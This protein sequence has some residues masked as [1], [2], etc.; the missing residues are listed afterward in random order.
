MN[1]K[2][3]PGIL[4]V[5]AALLIFP[6]TGAIPPAAAQAGPSVADLEL[7]AAVPAPLCPGGVIRYTL[8]LHNTAAAGGLLLA[9]IVDPIPANTAY[10]AGSATN[11]AAF[12]AAQNRVRWEGRLGPG[13]SASFAFEARVNN[14]VANGATIINNATGTLSDPAGAPSSDTAQHIAAVNCPTPTP[15]RTPTATNTPPVIVNPPTPTPTNTPPVIVIPP[16]ATPTPRPIASKLDVA[17]TSIEITQGTQSLQVLMP[18]VEKRNTIVRVYV[19]SVSGQTFV[20]VKARLKLYERMPNN[21]LIEKA[22]L[23]PKNKPQ[24]RPDGGDRLEMNHS[25]WFEMPVELT[26]GNVRFWAE[27]NYDNALADTDSGHNHLWIERAFSAVESIK[28][29]LVPVRAWPGGDPNKSWV[30]QYCKGGPYCM[31]ILAGLFRWHPVGEVNWTENS[32]ALTP[33]DPKD[34]WDPNNNDDRNEINIALASL[35]ALYEEYY[36]KMPKLSWYGMLASQFGTYGWANIGVAHGTWNNVLDAN[37][38]WLNVGS[39]ILAHE[40]GHNKGLNHVS[41]AGDANGNGVL[42]EDEAGSIDW[43]YPW[44]YQQ[45]DKGNVI[46]ECQI[47]D[48]DPKGYYGLDVYYK[49]GLLPAPVVISNDPAATTPNLG[50]PMMGY[51]WPNYISPWEYCK[52]LAA[53]GVSCT[54]ANVDGKAVAAVMPA[55]AAVQPAPAPV[56]QTATTPDQQTREHIL[57]AVSVNAARDTVKFYPALQLRDL[58]PESA[59]AIAANAAK[60]AHDGPEHGWFV[61]LEDAAGNPLAS[62]PISFETVPSH[63][64]DPS[65]LRFGGSFVDIVPFPTGVKYLRVRHDGALVASQTVSANPPSVQLLAPQ[66]GALTVGTTVQWQGSDFDGGPLHYTLLYSPDNGQSWQPLVINTTVTNISLTEDLLHDMPGSNQGKLKVLVTDGINTAEAVSTGLFNVAGSS[67]EIGVLAPVNGMKSPLGT[68][69]NFIANISD[70]EDGFLDGAAVRWV[71]D[72]DGELGTGAAFSTD[73]LSFGKH[74]ITLTATDRDSMTAQAT[75]Q[76]MVVGEQ[77]YL[78]VLLR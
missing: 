66:S 69:V 7:T 75:V 70:V 6:V 49:E 8:T 74:V 20:G 32:N 31:Q 51:K 72:R 37:S 28:L 67:P 1:S 3:I 15:T 57:L 61:T 44:S 68:V 16:T 26:K 38:P 71:S 22:T 2:I 29:R 59:A 50:Y 39:F 45:D 23:A 30:E 9:E 41:C 73:Q 4:L 11:G 54:W 78:P 58:P 34:A 48:I 46:S 52:M 19:K 10:V 12:D 56:I 5:L 55:P 40:L 27:L 13:Q 53:Y 18:L 76:I 33:A 42:D 14:G 64:E 62:H 77:V 60:P 21:Q 17:V 36:P 65:T 43:T 35:K 24:I 63:L 47:A 25:Y